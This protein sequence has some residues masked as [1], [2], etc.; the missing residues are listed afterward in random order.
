MALPPQFLE[1]LRARLPL[2]DVV[3]RRLRLLRAGR[4]FKAPC[5]FHNEKTPSFYVNDQKG[6]FH[7]FGCGAH[8][9]V[10]GF[11]MRH[12]RLS[13]I[14]AVEQLAGEAGLEVPKPTPQ[15]RERF[16]RQKTLYDVVE[17]AATWFEEQLKLPG[18]RAA[19]QYLRGRGLDDE[20]IAAFRLGY[21][22]GDAGGLRQR[23]EKDG[24][25]EAQ[26]IE[27]GL[28][29]Q[30]EDGRAPY[31][32]FRNRVMFPVTDRRGRVV[33]FGGRILEGDGPKYINSRDHA[34]FHKGRLLYGLS[35]ARHAASEGQ[36][37]I[38]V[39]GYMDVIAMVGAGFRGAVAPLGTALTE[40]QVEELWNAAPENNRI[41]IL[42]FDGDEAG[43]R[44]A[45]RSIDR[46]LP[47]LRPDQSVKVAFLPRGE[48]PDSLIRS[49]GPSA[50]RA[51]LESAHSLADMLW[52][53][54]T[55]GRRLDTPETRAGLKA[56]LEARVRAIADR[57]VQAFYMQ[58]IRRRIDAAFFARG[59][60]RQPG[61]QSPARSVPSAVR[62]RRPIKVGP[63]ERLLLAAVIN[64]SKLLHEFGEAL[65]EL[66]IADVELE[67]LRQAV[68]DCLSRE[69]DLDG[70]ALCS[71][72]SR[73]GFS[74]CLE[75]LLAASTYVHA[76]F[77][78][79]ETPIEDVRRGWEHVWALAQRRVLMAE[80]KN[81]GAELAR[82]TSPANYARVLA[83][84]KSQAAALGDAE[85]IET[86]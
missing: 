51:V 19:L 3:G 54:E 29:N 1:E 59:P 85:D 60:G 67:R 30:P 36:P 8:G 40:S 57:T 20:T 76:G 80:L 71:Q 37:L 69:P 5:P 39:E 6:F 23:L 7:C 65:S 32:F 79:P 55:A 26:M 61:R 10:V 2:S 13:F 58:E 44:A 72:L 75:G 73:L 17:A 41:P 12:D 68:L 9:D 45:V 78:R 66:E 31:S 64:H 11:V 74:A 48:D 70:P 38:V 35:R 56:A 27:A 49:A 22:P 52:Q 84:R 15:E 77:A 82:D 63:C 81:A 18:G 4:E 25:S 47:L 16:E 43:R 21:A 83:L 50:L 42:C 34:L 46:I 14:E 24:F 86:A 62:V 53:V 28:L 33:A